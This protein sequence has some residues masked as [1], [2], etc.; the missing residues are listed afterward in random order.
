MY[1]SRVRVA[2]EGLDRRRLLA[3]LSGD[4]YAN[5]QLLWR[6]FKDAPHRSFLFRQ[7]IEAD[8][9]R[10]GNQPRGLPLFYVLSEERP[11]AV[12]G[13]LEAESKPFSPVLVAGD[14]LTFRLRAN[15]T[16]S[17]K[18]ETGRSVRHDVLM[19]ARIQ[20]RQQGVDIPE[21]IQERMEEA[22]IRWLDRRSEKAGFTLESAPQ[23]TAYRQHVNRRKG[24]DIRFSSIDYE[25]VLTVM[26]PDLFNKTL[27]QGLGKSKA[28]GCGLMMVRRA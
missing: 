2:S 21:A 23:V 9:L 27:C 5:H 6:L 26:D 28:F 20:C 12:P 18:T 13:L 7:E 17:R 10:L 19:D 16:V 24:A 25:G 3:L 4:A 1:M 22:A 15:P 11:V 14:Q 8:Q